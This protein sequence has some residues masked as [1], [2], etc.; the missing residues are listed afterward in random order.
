VP[1]TARHFARRPRRGALVTALAGGSLALAAATIASAQTVPYEVVGDA[2]VEPLQGLVGD[3]ARG[4]A[5]VADRREGLC[6]LCHTGP[7]PEERF[8]GELSTSLTGVGRRWTPGQLRLRVVDA[9]RVNPDSLMP[10]YHRTEGL[11]RVG[12]TWQGRPVFSAQQVEDV[13]A[14]LSTLK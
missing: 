8:Q 14:F 10:A 2:I 3:A 9:R 12:S 6:L 4:R 1:G 7:F 13:V 5:L 11:Q